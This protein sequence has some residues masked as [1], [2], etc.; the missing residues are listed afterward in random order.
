MALHYGQV[1]KVYYEKKA[2]WIV[3]RERSPAGF[4]ARPLD[5]GVESPYAQG[6]TVLCAYLDAMGYVILGRVLAPQSD[7]P[8]DSEKTPEEL[9][10]ES[11][12]TLVGAFGDKPT[13]VPNY[14]KLTDEPLIPGDV[15]MKRKDKVKSF[16][17]LYS[18][19]SIVVD[20]DQILSFLFSS[21]DGSFNLRA[22]ELNFELV[23]GIKLNAV[24]KDMGQQKVIT[25]D[26]LLSNYND[27]AT[28]SDRENK[29]LNIKVDVQSDPD[30]S[31]DLY[32]EGGQCSSNGDWK[33]GKSPRTSGK[34]LE[35]GFKVRFGSFA[36]LEVDIPNKEIRVSMFIPP[37]SSQIFQLRMNPDEF[38][39]MRGDQFISF[40][41][42]GIFLKGKMIGI[43]GPWTMWSEADLAQFKQDSMPKTRSDGKP[44]LS[45]VCE[46]TGADPTKQG[47]KFTRSVYFGSKEEPAILQGF[48]ADTYT[49]DLQTLMSHTHN[50]ITPI[51]GNP[52]TP[53]VGQIPLWAV[54][55]AK[56]ST[57]ELYKDQLTIKI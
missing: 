13:Q 57:P 44:F 35:N 14:R 15:I 18:D 26:K 12:S 9:R 5:T 37:T 42:D 29:K 55:K 20:T 30:G 6:E 49:Q 24:H 8:E 54:E 43:A 10:A 48:L 21:F 31:P 33:N 19:G 3:S 34:A 39:L 11:A 52:T 47:I 22:E 4:W 2:Y 28:E 41:D 16:L 45:S 1:E 50:I 51:P 23:P 40:N 38:V 7:P 25:H 32:L 46:W 56:Y 53:A 36:D 27:G 17:G